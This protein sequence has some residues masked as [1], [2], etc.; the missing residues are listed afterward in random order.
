MT[1]VSRKDI[2]MPKIQ[3]KFD[4]RFLYRAHSIVVEV[5]KANWEG[6]IRFSEGSYVL[7]VRCRLRHCFY[8]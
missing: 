5:E 7:R 2:A 8:L 1:N 3:K 6:F 4:F